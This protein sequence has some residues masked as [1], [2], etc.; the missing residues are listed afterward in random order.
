M[1]FAFLIFLEFHLSIEDNGV[2][3]PVKHG[4][5]KSLLECQRSVKVLQ[6]SFRVVLNYA[7]EDGVKE[8]GIVDEI[9]YIFMGSH[10]DP[11]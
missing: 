6:P 1:H 7:G 10:A 8:V 4:C 3:S 9:K 11:S 5:L 2:E